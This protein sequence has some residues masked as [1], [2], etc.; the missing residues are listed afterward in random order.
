MASLPGPPGIAPAPGATPQFRLS[1]GTA[2]DLVGSTTTRGV[3]VTSA[4]DFTGGE[5][6][7]GLSPNTR[8]YYSINVNGT[9][10][11]TAPFPE[12]KTFPAEGVDTEVVIAA[13]SCQISPT[14]PV[15][16]ASIA[17]EAPTVFIHSGDFHYAD[18]TTVA[19]QRSNYQAQYASDFLS[20]IVRRMPRAHIWSDHDYGWNNADGGL[21]NKANSLQVFKEYIPTYPL[22]NPSNGVWQSFNVANGEVFMLDTRYNRQVR[23]PRYPEAPASTL[24]VQNG[25]SGTQ[26]VIVDGVNGPR[27]RFAD[28]YT[29]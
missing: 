13:G 22:A 10:A 24:V 11:H 18:V 9:R 2:N 7:T 8:Y 20:K 15:I 28:A 4:S 23:G 26:V 17:A 27:R 14:E 12:F 6:I 21:V 19:G 25:S 3:A 1:T 16:F 5:E 29:G